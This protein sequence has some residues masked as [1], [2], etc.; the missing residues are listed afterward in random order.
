[1]RET[2]DKNMKLCPFCKTPPPK[3]NEDR[4]KRVN[5]L[6]EKDNERAFNQIAGNYADGTMGLP[7]DWARANELYLKAGELGCAGAYY[8]LGI[9]YYNGNGVEVD[10]KKAKHYFELAVM[11]GDIDAR[12]NLGCMERQAG[13]HQRAFKHCLISARAGHKLSLNMVKKGYI[14]GFVTKDEYANTLRSYQK[15]QDEM[16]SDMRDKA[17][18]FY[19]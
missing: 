16:K 12:H 19:N 17:Q 9:H 6:M 3:S 4:V 11:N 13:N 15:S 1:M 10:M 2:G 5:K 7:Q 14:D 18:S 8:N